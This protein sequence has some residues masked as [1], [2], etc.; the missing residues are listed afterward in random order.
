MKK[1]Q[2]AV[3]GATGIIGQRF[4]QLLEDHPWFDLHGLYASERSEG[5]RLREVNKVKDHVFMPATMDRKVEQ[6]DPTKIAKSCRVAFSGLPSE[7]AKEYELQLAEAGVAVFSNA[8][9]HRMRDDVPLLIPEVN[10][11]HLDLIKKQPTFSKGGFIVTNANC[12]TTGLAPPLKAMQDAFGLEQVV[13]STYQAVSGAGY[14]GVP[15][16]DILGNVVPYIKGEEEKMEAEILKMLGTLKG[17]KVEDA[18]F[19]MFASC[20]RVPVING[21][22]ESVLVRCTKEP[23]ADDVI[24]VMRKFRAEPQKLELPTAP[25][26]AIIVRDEPDRPQPHWDVDAG[27]P[28]RARGM[29]V[30]VGRIRKKDN[31]VKFFLLSHN[32]LRGGAGGSVLNAE[33]ACA[34]GMLK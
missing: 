21:H 34:K 25:K 10:S 29:A 28:A 7:I 22:L 18:K 1:M 11:K 3:L 5:K 2:V 6:I 24:K 19:E 4:V 20:A 12:S 30:T 31:Y 23:S 27:E 33:L 13:V 32:T 17:G 14:P 16:L 9:S 15:S 8:A 26:E